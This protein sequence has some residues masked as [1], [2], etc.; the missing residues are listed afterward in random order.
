[1]NQDRKKELVAEAKAIAR[2]VDSWIALSNAVTDPVDGLI[3]RYFPDT[4]QREEFLRSPEYE[5][6]NQL[7]V[8]TIKKTGLYPR[9]ASGPNGEGD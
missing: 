1:M 4:R 7:L 6:L 8:R 3:A 9:A 5:E 2:R